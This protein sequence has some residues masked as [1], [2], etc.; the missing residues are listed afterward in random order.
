MKDYSVILP[1]ETKLNENN[2]LA[3]HIEYLEDLRPKLQKHRSSKNKYLNIFFYDDC[4][5]GR[6]ILSFPSP[7]NPGLYSANCIYVLKC[8][9]IT[10]SKHIW[11]VKNINFLIE[12]KL[13]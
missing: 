8:P 4:H 2:N 6:G 5:S 12:N 3:I 10:Y 13:L 7:Q 9:I 1:N 11:S